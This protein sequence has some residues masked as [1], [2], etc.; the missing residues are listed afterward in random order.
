M[1]R[2]ARGEALVLF[3]TLAVTLLHDLMW[4]IIAGTALAMVL[5]RLRKA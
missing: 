2:H 5:G 3:T 4:G 1:L